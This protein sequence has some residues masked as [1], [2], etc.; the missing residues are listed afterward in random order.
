MTRQTIDRIRRHAFLRRLIFAALVLATIVLGALA[1]ASALAANGINGLEWIQLSLFVI[2]FAWIA[3]SFWTSLFGFAVIL[4]G[5]DPFAITRT[6]EP[7]EAGRR[8]GVR[9]A[10]VVPVFNEEP[11]RVMA[12]VAS[13]MSSLDDRGVLGDFDFYILSDTNDPDIWVE[14]ELAFARLRRTAP[15]PQRLFYRKRRENTDRKVGNI[16]DFCARW[17]DRYRYMIVF[18]ADSVMSGGTLMHMVRLMER[19]PGVGLIQVPPMPVNRET[20]FG[21]IQQFATGA[22]GTMFATGLNWWQA[23]EGNYWGHNAI[24]RIRPFVEHCRLPV[25]SG[26]E[27]LGGA[28]LSHDF[29][30]AALMRRAGWTVWLASELDGSYEETPPTLIDHA[31]RDRRWCQGNLQHIRLIGTR[32]LNTISRLHLL[33]G[34]MSYL[35]SPI[36]M[37]LLLVA[38]VEAGRAAMLGPVYFDPERSLFPVWQVSTTTR[39]LILY[40]VTLGMLLAPKLLAIVAH[41]AKRRLHSFGGGVRLTFSVLLEALFS[42]LLAPIMAV[43]QTR[44]VLSILGGRKVTWAGQQR[45][46]ATTTLADAARRHGGTTALGLL[47]GLAAWRFMPDFFWWLTPVL[48]GMVLSI[49]LSILSSRPDIGR[50]ARAAGI[51]LIPEEIDPPQ[52]LARLPRFRSQLRGQD[53]LASGLARLIHDPEARR[54]HFELLPEPIELDPL[55]RHHLAGLRLKVRL[56]GLDSLTR[57]ERME[58]LLD[59]FSL[60]ALAHEMGGADLPPPAAEGEPVAVLALRPS[61]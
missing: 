28:I 39:T 36:W 53:P 17:G 19:N 40:L 21:R 49:P 32:G 15:E 37:L 33:M 42:M 16:A 13:T 23:G 8:L 54:A 12:G 24:I 3:P 51:F 30:E 60:E 57:A 56:R 55:Q 59:R 25:L 58:L 20:L 27:P 2:L 61:H 48:A 41:A 22:Y 46:D 5:G 43:L 18:D 34:I 44:F 1:M 29:V 45:Q 10:I 47:W 50:A 35:A 31:A 52:V 9:T 7:W 6:L 26:K 11:E 4:R 14:E 38:T